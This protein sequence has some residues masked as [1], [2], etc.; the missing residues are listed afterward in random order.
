MSCWNSHKQHSIV[1]TWLFSGKTTKRSRETSEDVN[2]K[3]CGAIE[4]TNKDMRPGPALINCVMTCLFTGSGPPLQGWGNT[5]SSLASI[6]HLETAEG[7]RYKNL[8]LSGRLLLMAVTTELKVP[9]GPEWTA[10]PFVLESQINPLRQCLVK[11]G[12]WDKWLHVLS[13]KNNNFACAGWYWLVTFLSTLQVSSSYS[14]WFLK[15]LA[16]KNQPLFWKQV[17]LSCYYRKTSLLIM[18]EHI[19]VRNWMIILETEERWLADSASTES[20]IF[21][22]W[23]IHALNLCCLFTSPVS[24]HYTKGWPAVWSEHGHWE[25]QEHNE[26]LRMP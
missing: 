12:L 3:V 19:L 23:F 9:K 8:R 15:L 16:W 1:T 22:D 24:E 14:H 25:P 11:S 26:S 21:I 6:L 20:I 18:S 7:P 10:V 2:H 5:R 17:L 4:T 13:L